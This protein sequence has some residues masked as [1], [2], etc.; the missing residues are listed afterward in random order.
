VNKAKFSA[1]ERI[2][3]AAFLICGC[4]VVALLAVSRFVPKPARQ[5]QVAAPSSQPAISTS[6]GPPTE[7]RVATSTISPTITLEPIHASTSAQTEIRQPLAEPYKALELAVRDEL[8]VSNRDIERIAEVTVDEGLIRVKFAIQGDF[9]SD[10]I[11]RGAQSDIWDI[12]RLVS[13]SDIEY[14]DVLL[15]GTFALQDSTGDVFEAQVVRTEHSRETVERINWVNYS[16]E[17]V[18]SS[19][20]WYWV[21]DAMQD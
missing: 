10:L 3:I 17:D 12:L 21:H 11:M 16:P 19:A 4:F 6:N 18:F 8:G 9:S 13:D 2:V 20:N 5:Q 15:F 14:D 1:L 7:T